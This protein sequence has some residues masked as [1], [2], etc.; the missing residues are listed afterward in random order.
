MPM[1]TLFL[2]PEV[3]AAA[4]IEEFEV[5][6]TVE[7]IES[8]PVTLP[9]YRPAAPEVAPEVQS[10][11]SA[12]ILTRLLSMA[13]QYRASGSMRQAI[14]MYF[15]LL[16]QHSETPQGQ[17]AEERLFEVARSYERSG[18]LRQA[19]GIYEQLI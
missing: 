6:E 10:A 17:R 4:V 5:E 18:E 3:Q 16:R 7:H 2:E 8:R 9:P 15:E 13:D 11:S 12:R 19:R 1:N 14:E